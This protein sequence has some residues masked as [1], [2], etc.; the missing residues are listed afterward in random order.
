VEDF[1]GDGYPYREY[2]EEEF[3]LEKCESGKMLVLCAVTPEGQI[4]GTSALCLEEEFKGSALLMLRV[5]KEEYRGM[6]IG[7]VQED[8]LFQYVEQQHFLSV[9]ADVM[10]HNCVSQ[11]SLARRGFVYCGLRMM[12]YRNS[13]M[14]PKLGLWRDGKVT[15]AI[16]CRR[17]GAKDAGVLRCPAEHARM[18]CQIY[19]QLGAACSI[20][21]DV[22]LPSGKQTFFT[23]KKEE[24]HHSCILTVQRAGMDFSE[25]LRG[26][27]ELLG[28]WA[29]ATAL[30]Y[31]NIKDIAAN[32]AY[33]RLRQAGFYFT[34]LKPLQE[35]AEYMLLAYTGRQSVRFQDIHL[36]GEGE[37]LLSY[38]R[39]HRLCR[40]GEHV[41]E[42]D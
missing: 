26:T 15:Q 28:G 41:I 16:M 42:N 4:V 27:M 2:L 33:G 5:V 18:V 20:D 6:G 34:G 32:F 36:Y 17:D 12:L 3:L 21:T 19:Q 40:K 9:Y 23:W 37:K 22:I 13:V 1:Y 31:L 10:T 11:C 38:I 29:D 35:R 25:V 39:K 30:C 24:L 8:R 7:K 14:V